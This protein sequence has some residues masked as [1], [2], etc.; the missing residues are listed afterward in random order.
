MLISAL[1]TS[2]SAGSPL[3]LRSN[4]RYEKSI[5]H[6]TKFKQKTKDRETVFGIPFTYLLLVHSQVSDFRIE[7]L[8]HECSLLSLQGRSC[9]E[10]LDEYYLEFF[11]QR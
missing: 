4:Q 5:I 9:L 10:G 2:L 1:G 6:F 3:A 11:G 8:Q 7:S